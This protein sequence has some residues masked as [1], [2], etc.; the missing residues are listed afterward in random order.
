MSIEQIDAVTYDVQ[1]E[2]DPTKTYMVWNSWRIGWTCTCMWF[3]I[4]ERLHP[5]HPMCK[6][7]KKVLET[8]IRHK[9]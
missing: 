5:P 2:T 8:H 4:H 7:I 1:S 3:T 6:H 9:K